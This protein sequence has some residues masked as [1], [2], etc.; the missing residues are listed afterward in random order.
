MP[1][2]IQFWRPLCSYQILSLSGRGCGSFTLADSEPLI[3]WCLAE[4]DFVAEIHWDYN[5]DCSPPHRSKQRWI[6]L[7]SLS[8]PSSIPH[9]FQSYQPIESILAY[10]L[11]SQHSKMFAGDVS[12][13]MGRADNTVTVQLIRNT[14]KCHTEMKKSIWAMFIVY[15]CLLCTLSLQSQRHDSQ[16]VTVSNQIIFIIITCDECVCASDVPSKYSTICF[17]L[18][19]HKIRSVHFHIKCWKWTN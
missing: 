13:D 8:L 15:I 7:V 10:F 11:H 1:T 12:V 6:V 5:I 18:T 9:I 16:L 3:V 17:A 2:E 14:R 4:Y 19:L